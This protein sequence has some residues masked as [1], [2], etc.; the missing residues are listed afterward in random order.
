M[1]I[2]LISKYG[3]LPG[4]A[5]SEEQKNIKNTCQKAWKIVLKTFLQLLNVN[6]L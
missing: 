4:A 3:C 5:R 1:V 2:S 6:I